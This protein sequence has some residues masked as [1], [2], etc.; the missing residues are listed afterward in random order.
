MVLDA[1]LAR[2]VE[3]SPITVMA[4][5]ALSRALAPAWL[6]ALFELHRQRQYTR[7]LLFSS[8]V[9]LMAVV[10]VGLAAVGA[11]GG[12]GAQGLAGV[13]GRAVRQDQQH[14]AGVGPGAGDWQRSTPGA[15]R[16][17]DS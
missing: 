16:A 8:V 15:A 17:R 12:A 10:A 13:P 2:F 11:C 6:D 14:G 3:H 9:D 4:Q 1:V 7:D 5:M